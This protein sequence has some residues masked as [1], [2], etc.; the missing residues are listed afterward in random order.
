MTAPSFRRLVE[1][2]LRLCQP[3]ERGQHTVGANRGDEPAERGITDRVR[4]AAVAVGVAFCAAVE[5]RFH[6]RWTRAENGSG[7]LERRRDRD[8]AAN[9]SGGT[10]RPP[11]F[12]IA[13]RFS[14]M[15]AA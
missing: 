9:P 8:L 12:R 1:R 6:Q 10:A 5:L 15:P 2:Q 3:I 4:I 11:P 14:E 7:E 13:E